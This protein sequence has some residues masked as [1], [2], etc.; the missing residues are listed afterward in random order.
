MPM[1]S[2]LKAVL[3]AAVLA[4]V[5]SFPE[6]LLAQARTERVQFV[7]GASSSSIKGRIQG[8]A[9]VDYQVRAGAGQTIAVTLKPSNPQNYFNVLPPGSGGEAMF[10]GSMGGDYSGV[11]PTDGDYLIRVYLMRPAARRGES[12][13]YS[14]S[15]GVT[16]KALAPVAAS[17]DALIPGTPFHASAPIKCVPF[18]ETIPRECPAFV[19]RRG[20]DGTGTV[21]IPGAVKRSILFVKGKPVASNAQATTDPMTFERQSDTTV[22]RLGRDERYEIPDALLTGG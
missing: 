20:L 21:E 7:K 19:M 1:T 8:D 17:V 15:V 16:G 22:V 6:A 18:L 10:V 4:A 2:N 13:D 11:L 9:M 14:L 3:A 5:V 12:S